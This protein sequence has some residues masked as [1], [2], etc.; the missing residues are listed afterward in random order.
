MVLSLDSI[1]PYSWSV[2]SE[3]NPTR[4]AGVC[5][6]GYFAAAAV[7]L[8]N[9][10][11]MAVFRSGALPVAL[12][13]ACLPVICAV[14][15]GMVLAGRRRAPRLAVVV[16]GGFCAIHL[17]GLAYLFLI[18]PGSASPLTQSLQWQLGTALLFLW[19][20]V[21]WSAFLLANGVGPSRSGDRSAGM[22]PPGG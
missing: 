11:V 9:V 3:P 2:M 10:I 5:A 15:G 20:V 16:A 8:A 18:A 1:R 13:M 14:M 19:L 12:A 4:W 21:L 6:G 22:S 7:Y 17:I